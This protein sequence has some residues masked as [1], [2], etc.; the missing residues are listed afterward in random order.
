MS[1]EKAMFA[2]AL[3]PLS[4]DTESMDGWRSRMPMWV[5]AIPTLG[6]NASTL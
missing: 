5:Q 6:H 3:Q 4:D 1:E 2:D